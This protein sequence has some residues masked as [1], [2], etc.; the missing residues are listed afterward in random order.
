MTS[1]GVL[2]RDK[3]LDY[4]KKREIVIEPILDKEQI[5][6]ASIN[7]RLDNYFAEFRTAKTSHIDPATIGD[8]YKQFLDFVEIDFFQDPY[9]LQPKRFVLAQTFEYISL[10]NYIVGHLEGRSSVAREGLTVHA[11]AGLVDPGFRGHLVFELLNA[12]EMPLALYPLMCVAKI[13]FD[14]TE[15]TEPY[16]GRYRGQVR[17]MPPGKD[18]E[19]IK[20]REIKKRLSQERSLSIIQSN[21][22]SN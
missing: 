20:I 10:P 16:S 21:R 4:L 8:L 6:C 7:L 18:E 9:Y 5:D 15:K 22:V 14:R 11:A 19:V 1:K 3:I 2:T 12:G 13:S 17:I